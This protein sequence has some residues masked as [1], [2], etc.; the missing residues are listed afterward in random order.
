MEIKNAVLKEQVVSFS[1][2]KIFF[3]IFSIIVFG[4]FIYYYSTIKGGVKIFATLNPVWIVVALVTQGSTYFFGALIYRNLLRALTIEPLI[5]VKELFQAAIVTLF[6]TQTIPSASV[7]GHMFFFNFLKKRNVS[8]DRALSLILIELL[9]FYSGIILIIIGLLLV[10][11]CSASMPMFFV[12]ILFGGLVVY[13]I[14]AL[15]VEFFGK[16]HVVSFLMRKISNISFLK[17]RIKKYERVSSWTPQSPLEICLKHRR[18]IL[19][20]VILQCCI[21]FADGVTVYALFRGL[22]VSASFLVVFMGLIL[23]IAISLLPISPG[24][25]LV[26]E[27]SMTFFYASL[28]I[29][30]VIAATVTLL[31]RIVSFWVPIPIGLFFYRKLQRFSQK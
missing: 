14:L 10:C 27:A 22:N 3:Y 11:F 7:S 23:T 1:K 2:S 8:E 16:G 15:L 17:K 13:V 28:G 21:F 9:T 29:P 26:Y 19:W 12:P 6:V 30:V 24:A 31:Y 25:L 4:L 5:S 18:V 20:S